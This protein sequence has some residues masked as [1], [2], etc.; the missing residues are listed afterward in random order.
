MRPLF[1]TDEERAIAKRI[2]DHAAR[3]E[4]WFRPDR[5]GRPP[6]DNPAHHADFWTYSCVFSYSVTQG[7][8]LRHLSVRVPGKHLPNPF[9]VMTLAE[10][11]GFQGW[12]QQSSQ[13][14]KDWQIGINDEERTVVVL[15]KIM[16]VDTGTFEAV[17]DEEGTP[18]RSVDDLPEAPD[19]NG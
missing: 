16:H 17:A 5:G 11:F 10:L 19:A 4:N 9:A 7:D 3:R 18:V 2:V 1:I 8:L 14:P 6:G 15:Q 12:D 13:P